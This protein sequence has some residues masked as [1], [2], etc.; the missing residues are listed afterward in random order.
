MSFHP[1]VVLAGKTFTEISPGRY[2]NEASTVTEP[3]TLWI[4][5]TV[6]PDSIS[7]YV[8]KRTFAQDSGNTII[9]NTM[10]VADDIL[11]VHLVIKGDLRVFS[12]AQITDV[13]SEVTEFCT[14]FTNLQKLLRGER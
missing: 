7:S 6:K 3:D 13:I 4:D 9:G 10:T 14:N 1:N 2:L 12:Q 11:Q 8:V 5:S